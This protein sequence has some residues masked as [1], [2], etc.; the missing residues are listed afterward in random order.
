MASTAS[1]YG[2]R[3]VNLIGGQAF[4]GGVIR[5]FPVKANNSAAIFNGDLVVL[6]SAG[7]PSA[8]T[9]T[10]VAITL[11]ATSVIA[12]AGI[13]GVCVGA[14]YVNSEGQLTFNNYLPAGLVTGGASDVFVR[15]MDDPDALM[16]I[17]AS[18]ALG[19]FNSGSSGSGFAGAVGKNAQLGFSTAGNTTTGNSGMNLLTGTNGNG[20][21]TTQSYGVRIVGFREGTQEDTYPEFVV[22]LNVG[23]HSYQNSTGV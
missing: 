2:L 15:V 4:N 12:T 9:S 22:K 21:V 6:S 14:R 5:E 13:V 1:P 20:L 10:P 23:V 17:Q 7:L 11:A 3:P 8:V 18:A 16:E 19:T